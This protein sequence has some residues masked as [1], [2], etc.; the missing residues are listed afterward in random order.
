MNKPKPREITLIDPKYQPS[1]AELR[2]DLRVNAT[3]EQA[4][5]AL[6]RPVR[7]K[8]AMPSKPKR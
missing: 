3:P 1:A 4:R 7:I 5:A 8:Y 2:E 6:V